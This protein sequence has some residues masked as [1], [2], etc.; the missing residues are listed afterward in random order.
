MPT[1]EVAHDRADDHDLWL[2]RFDDGELLLDGYVKVQGGLK[3]FVGRPPDTSLMTALHLTLTHG[4]FS[5]RP[6]RLADRCDGSINAPVLALYLD[7][8]ARH[9]LDA[10]A[11]HAKAYP[12]ER[13][14]EE[15]AIAAFAHWQGVLIPHTWT[16]ACFQ[17]LLE[18]LTQIN[19]LTLGGVL[20][21][22]TAG[23][24]FPEGVLAREGYTCFRG[25]TRCYGPTARF[26]W[27]YV[28]TPTGEQVWQSL[29][30]GLRNDPWQSTNG[31]VPAHYGLSFIAVAATRDGNTPLARRLIKE[32]E[33][34]GRS[35]ANK[36]HYQ[37]WLENLEA[38]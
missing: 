2:G 30:G 35:P 21:D 6:Y 15:K 19:H 26:T 14:L 25:N 1:T 29:E 18:S 17:G 9:E 37:S 24:S 7:F 31:V 13:A 34:S 5:G 16:A 23:I 22:A 32:A 12:G 8:C 4:F 10:Q 27:G 11:L 33:R 20:A 36:R 28:I 38:A 3:H